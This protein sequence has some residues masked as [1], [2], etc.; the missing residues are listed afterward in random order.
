MQ[1]FSHSGYLT[2]FVPLCHVM[3]LW[4]AVSIFYAQEMGWCGHQYYQ[5][6]LV[7]FSVYPH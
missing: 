6:F 2:I 5:T 1:G 7:L 4:C 3:S